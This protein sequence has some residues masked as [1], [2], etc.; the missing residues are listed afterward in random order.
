[1]KPKLFLVPLAAACV[2]GAL[3]VTQPTPV[4]ADEERD[5]AQLRARVKLLEARLEALDK[6]TCDQQTAIEELRLAQR[7]LEASPTG[8][9][10]ERAATPAP[11]R[12]DAG[13]AGRLD[14]AKDL[15]RRGDLEQ[16]QAE[17]LRLLEG[18]A[19]AQ[20]VEAR[21]L[22]VQV[23]L[24]RKEHERALALLGDVLRLDPRSAQA[25]VLRGGA[26]YEQGR[27]AEALEDLSRAIELAP[28]D[29]HA[30]YDRAI[31][32]CQR[33]DF[34]AAIRDLDAAEARYRRSEQPR[35]KDL[36]DVYRVRAA[37]R[38]SR[39]EPHEAAADCERY[40]K[41]APEGRA[42]AEV[43]KI[44]AEARERLENRGR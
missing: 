21:L 4:Q 28:D 32:S 3:S 5:Q 26:H 6:L 25:Y 8:P 41:L 42:R 10:P 1:M 27:F 13:Y 34:A 31:V 35:P 43:E 12:D 38:L 14:L 36:A 9:A 23:S 24:R 44:L 39:D 19:P 15:L 18:R 30:Y 29:A 22:L 33:R 2:V 37:C 7:R 17:L 40:L 20:Q 11:R 16:A